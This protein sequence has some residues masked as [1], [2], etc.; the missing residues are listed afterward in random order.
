ML[1]R[2]ALLQLD[3]LIA[4]VENGLMLKD[5]TPYNVQWRGTEPVFIDV[6]S[7]E[8]LREGEPWAG[9]RQFCQLQLFPLMLQAFRDVPYHAWLR[10]SLEGITPAELRNLLRLRDR[11]HR[12]VLTHVVL[13]AKLEARYADRTREVRERAA[14]R[15]ASA[16]SWC[17]RTPAGCAR[18]SA[19]WSGTARAPPGAATATTN[20]YGESDTELKAAFVRAAA[21]SSARRSSGIWAATTAGSPRSP[22]ST[23]RPSW[24]STA[25]TP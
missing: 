25:T 17:S 19:A 12:G 10:G 24:P 5:G 6:G 1:Q 7:F 4:S 20:T 11:F 14:A 22:A 15:P 21:A 9:Y 13:H 2:A 23:R 3:L 18:S 8:R 16:R